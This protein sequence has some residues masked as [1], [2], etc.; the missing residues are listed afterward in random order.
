[1][2]RAGGVAGLPAVAVAGEDGGDVLGAEAMKVQMKAAG[3]F[4]PERS[5]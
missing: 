3:K 2:G 5:G 4:T 1:M